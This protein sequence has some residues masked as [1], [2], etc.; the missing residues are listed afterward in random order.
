MKKIVL[1][2]GQYAIVDD[3]DFE[4]LNQW[5]WFASKDHNTFYANRRHGKTIMQMHRLLMKPKKYEVVDHINRNGLD[6]R[7]IN[8]RICSSKENIRSAP[9]HK[10][11]TSQFKGVHLPSGRNKWRVGIRVDGKRKFV[12]TFFSEIDAAKAYNNAAK[13]YF[14]RFAFLNDIKGTQTVLEKIE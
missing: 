12:G 5:K 14:G 4:Y 1:T 8:L 10:K 2:K 11:K 6:N 9:K 7:R 3:E 13:K